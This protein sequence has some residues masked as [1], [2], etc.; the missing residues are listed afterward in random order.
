MDYKD[1]IRKLLAL[2]Q[3]PEEGE[4]KAALLKAR[5]LMVKYK[6]SEADVRGSKKTSVKKELTNTTFSMQRDPWI[7]N[8][9][10]EI[11]ENYC[12]E[13][14]IQHTKGKKTYT[15]GFVGL[16]DDMA[17]CLP[18]FRY[19]LDSV[20]SRNRRT[21]KQLADHPTAYVNNL[22]NGYGYGFVSG[23]REAF[24][25]QMANHSEEW[26]LVLVKPKE[27]MDAVSGWKQRTYHSRAA[28]QI[29]LREYQNGVA[30][31]KRFDPARRLHGSEG[32]MFSQ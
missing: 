2:A 11:G 24:R 5:E 7:N 22:C 20:L 31:G 14:Y 13:A 32:R 21:R 19:A 10:V 8:L 16:E 17:V 12:C 18:V 23:L 27:V 28:N 26:G 1:R 25:Q 3:S 29:D 4:A 9:A 30:D 15:V 6:L